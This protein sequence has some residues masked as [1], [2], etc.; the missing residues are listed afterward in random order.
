MEYQRA[1]ICFFYNSDLEILENEQ[2]L[3]DGITGYS[4]HN[5]SRIHALEDNTLL[6][7]TGDAQN[8]SDSQNVNILTEKL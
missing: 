2:I 1:F 3:I 4:T 7:S 8:Q 6:M 5:G